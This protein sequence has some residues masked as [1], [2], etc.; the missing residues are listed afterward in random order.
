MEFTQP[1]QHKKK[2]QKK[3]QKPGIAVDNEI[4]VE[5]PE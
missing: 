4:Q 5:G 1:K 2:Q 3:R